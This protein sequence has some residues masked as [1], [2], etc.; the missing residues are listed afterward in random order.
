MAPLG[1]IFPPIHTCAAS[2]AT[3]FVSYH[4]LI[5]ASFPDG[6]I[7]AAAIVIATAVRPDADIELRER[8][9]RLAI[10][11]STHLSGK[12]RKGPQSTRSSQNHRQFSH[13]DLL[14]PTL[15]PSTSRSHF[16]S[17]TVYFPV[18][19]HGCSFAHATSWKQDY[20]QTN[21]I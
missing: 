3:A 4:D 5:A 7:T 13:L 17:L 16:R 2:P 21:E 11:W 20:S 19:E 14:V 12:C 18:K 15:P 6:H 8:N 10:R 1:A 9:C